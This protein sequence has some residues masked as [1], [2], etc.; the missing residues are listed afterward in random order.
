MEER[1]QGLKSRERQVAAPCLSCLWQKSH[2]PFHDEEEIGP[3]ML[4]RISKKTGLKP[5]DL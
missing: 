2:L 3:R 1:P 5:A 4:A